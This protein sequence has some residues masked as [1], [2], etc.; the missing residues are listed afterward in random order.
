MHIRRARAED[1][2]QIVA[3]LADDHLGRGRENTADLRPYQQA[4]AAIEADGNQFL[5]VAEED[6]ELI[7]TMQLTFIPGLSRQGGTRALV[8]AVR[9]RADRRSG[10]RGARLMKWAVDEAR[11]RGCAM[12]QLTSDAS[13]FDAHRF[14]EKL[15]FE[16]SHLGFKLLL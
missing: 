2:G 10:G 15:G 14:Y 5:A 6:G 9:V 7:G 12:I 11:R 16:Q 13:R 1:V 4:F 3:M 8:E